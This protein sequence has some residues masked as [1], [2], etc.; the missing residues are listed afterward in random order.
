MPDD[1]GRLFATD[2]AAR[3]GIQP[4][5]WRARVSRG[6][7]P[8]PDGHAPS[9]GAVRAYWLPATFEAYLQSRGAR[10]AASARAAAESLKATGDVIQAAGVPDGD[11]PE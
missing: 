11:R 1:K 2:I 8:K 5:D 6:H 9:R 10:L 3:L 4:S 7:A